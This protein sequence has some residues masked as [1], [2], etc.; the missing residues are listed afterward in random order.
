MSKVKTSYSLPSIRE[1]TMVIPQYRIPVTPQFDY[2]ENVDHDVEHV[3]QPHNIRQGQT[4]YI[5]EK[6][7]RHVAGN[8]NTISD[9]KMDYIDDGTALNIRTSAAPPCDKRGAI[10][11]SHKQVEA[12]RMALRQKYSQ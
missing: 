9:F 7:G 6:T 4:R 10:W 8:L 1:G 12:L 5:R 11:E 2:I 3:P